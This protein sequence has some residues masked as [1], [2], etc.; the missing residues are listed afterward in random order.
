[1]KNGKLNLP[2]LKI[3]YIIFTWMFSQLRKGSYLNIKTTSLFR[4]NYLTHRYAL[5]KTSS[6]IYLTCL[7]TVI[8]VITALPYLKTSVSVKSKGILQSTIEKVE[9]QSSI[10]GKVLD[11]Y[12]KDNQSI[13]QGDTLLTIDASLQGKKDHFI[14]KRI[15]TLNNFLEDLTKLTSSSHSANLPF[16][17]SQ[18]QV[19]YNQFIEDIQNSENAKQQAETTFRRYET[20]YKEKVITDAEFEKYSFELKQ[21][22]VNKQL[23]IQ[24][25]QTQWQTEITQYKE[26]FRQLQSESAEVDEQEKL[27][28]LKAPINGSLQ[29]LAGVQ[30]GAYVFANQKIADI[31]PDSN[32]IAFCYIKPSDIG[33]IKKGQEVRLNIDA[34]NY[35]QWG[36]ITGKV[37]DISNDILI[38]DN[39]PHFKVKCSLEQNYLQLKNGYKGFIK[40]GMTFNA[41]FLV[42]ERSLYQ[43]LYDKVDDWVNPNLVPN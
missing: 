6:V 16:K 25:Y 8:L 4:M 17:T 24:K 2:F 20:L 10:N 41:R 36:F 21:A 37:L 30:A 22:I 42:A 19:T 7:I 5:S 27:Y 33:L 40:K 32:I 1:M 14:N 38:T 15:A 39:Q 13:K 23:M 28:V 34:F 29:N 12:F 18:Y 11:I 43:L 31:S 35:N 9:L 26:E 3:C